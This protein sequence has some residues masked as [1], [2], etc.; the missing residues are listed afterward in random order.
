MIIRR[1]NI[2]IYANET[3]NYFYLIHY[4]IFSYLVNGACKVHYA[5]SHESI[6]KPHPENLNADHTLLSSL[7]H[8]AEPF[9]RSFQLCSYSRTSQHFMEPGGKDGYFS[10]LILKRLKH[11][12]ISIVL[13]I[14]CTIVL[15]YYFI[16]ILFL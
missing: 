10:K 1:R 12:K 11:F 5:C 3:D 4:L 13:N 14:Y 8:G 2:N 7:T 6:N 15:P 16:N 9:L